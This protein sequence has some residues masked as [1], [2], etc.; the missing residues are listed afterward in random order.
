MALLHDVGKLGVSNS[1]LDKPGKLSGEEWQEIHKHP[2]F[3]ED[4]LKRITALGEA[5]FVAA[6]H[7]ERLDGKGYPRG[8]GGDDIVLETRILT[9]A[10]IFDA[11]TADR[12]YRPAMPVEKALL[13]MRDMTHTAIDKR[14]FDALVVALDRQRP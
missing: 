5:A 4:V 1:I 8:I 3:T 14:C 2:E 11:L 12:P 13:L 10:D 9:A 7:H 6:A